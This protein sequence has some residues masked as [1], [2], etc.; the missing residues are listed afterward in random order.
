MLERMVDLRHICKGRKAVSTI[1]A[2]ILTINMAIVMGGIMVAWAMGLI[3]SYQG[4]Y[5]IQYVLMGEKAQ[6]VITVENVWFETGTPK[7]ITVFVR[8]V[9]AR[10]AKLVSLYVGGSSYTPNGTWP[11][12]LPVSPASASRVMLQ[13]TY[14]W[15]S[16][17]SYLIVVATARGN[18]ARGQWTA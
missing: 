18:Q 16:N 10:E 9:G 13:I 14:T 7:K 6:E 5:Q 17:T 3:G 15:T 11:Y 1:V 4:G 12:T 8:N 2:T